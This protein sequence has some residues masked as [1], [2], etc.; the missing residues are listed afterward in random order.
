MLSIDVAEYIA[1]DSGYSQLLWVKQ[2]LKGYEFSQG[3]KSLFFDNKSEIE[4][5]MNLVQHS[6]MKHIDIRHHFI[7]QLME[8]KVVTLDY[9]KT[10]DQL[11]DILTKPLDSKRFEYLWCSIGLCAIY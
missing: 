1:A 9:V 10:E 8:D 11:V 4:I 2:M 6:R 5:S 7:Q 3:T